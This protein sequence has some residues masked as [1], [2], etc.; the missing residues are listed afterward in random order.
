[1][2]LY[3]LKEEQLRL[4]EILA[5]PDTDAKEL[6]DTIEQV[7]ADFRDKADAYGMVYTEMM[8]DVEK[9]QDEIDRLTAKRKAKVVEAEAAA[10]AAA[11]TAE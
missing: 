6:Q 1:M 11:P 5:D 3:E 8:A 2:T 7:E 10:A 4:M 9:L